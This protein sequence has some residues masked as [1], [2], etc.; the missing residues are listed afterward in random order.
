MKKICGGQHTTQADQGQPKPPGHTPHGAGPDTVCGYDIFYG[1]KL[2][3]SKTAHD[4]LKI[5]LFFPKV[6]PFRDVGGLVRPNL[7]ISRFF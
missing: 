2:I 7:E 3:F 5:I 1:E 4:C 6:W